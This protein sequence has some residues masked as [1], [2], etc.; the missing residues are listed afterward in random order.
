MKYAQQKRRTALGK[1]ALSKSMNPAKIYENCLRY[2]GFKPPQLNADWLLAITVLLLATTLLINFSDLITRNPLFST[3]Y[4]YL[5]LG[6]YVLI[7]GLVTWLI[8]SIK[9]DIGVVISGAALL[10]F[11][12]SSLPLLSIVF[13]GGG[14]WGNA[15]LN[16]LTLSGLPIDSI[17]LFYTIIFIGASIYIGNPIFNLF[18]FLRKLMQ[19]AIAEDNIVHAAQNREFPHDKKPEKV[20]L[21][22]KYQSP[23]TQ[24]LDT[25]KITGAKSLRTIS[26]PV[27]HREIIKLPKGSDTALLKRNL[28]N[29]KRDFGK[30]LIITDFIE[31]HLGCI[32]IDVPSRTRK[33]VKYQELY[34]SAE[35]QESLATIPLLMGK[36]TQGDIVI[37]DLTQMPHMLIAGRSGSG[38]T[39]AAH[40]IICSLA[41][42]FSPEKIK[43][44][45]VDLKRM[46]MAFYDDLPHL[47][48]K[49]AYTFDQAHRVADG[50]IA[51]MERRKHIIADASCINHAHFNQK[52][53]KKALPFIIFMIDEAA[54]IFT[55]QKTED[56]EDEKKTKSYRSII[57]P[58]MSLISQQARA[59]GIHLIPMT[60]KPTKSAL[61]DEFQANI[62]QRIC[63]TTKDEE[64]SKYVINKPDAAYLLGKG[65]SFYYNSNS[66][67]YTRLH[68]P[69]LDAEGGELEE[70]IKKIKQKWS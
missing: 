52:N 34:N 17:V 58:V 1:T 15:L 66:S 49:T 18:R 27:I 37:E 69:F 68:T 45:L 31:G 26:G 55:N 23:I 19:P 6:T 13:A 50:I 29:L 51:E 61:P 33:I 30:P 9:T 63:L 11:I 28:S 25:Y 43:F 32:G 67:E 10:F 5:G 20:E 48:G 24:L 57:L 7:Y 62:A 44:Q 2:F 4:E 56:P 53:P 36:D 64:D 41:M 42:R 54:S 3:T 60:Q 8:W 14:V 16:I 40:S 59:I 47:A 46:D 35:F 12:G 22:Q 65:D 38:K 21:D 39:S 70:T